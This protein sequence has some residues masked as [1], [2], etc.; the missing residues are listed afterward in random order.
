VQC[1]LCSDQSSRHSCASRPTTFEFQLLAGGAQD[2]QA[3]NEY[4][5]TMS[6]MMDMAMKEFDSS[7]EVFP[8]HFTCLGWE[9]LAVKLTDNPDILSTLSCS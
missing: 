8:I 3:G 1:E 6:L 9:A 2:L 7:G 4:Y 5:D